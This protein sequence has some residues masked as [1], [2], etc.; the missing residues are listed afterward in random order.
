VCPPRR[1]EGFGPGRSWLC[2]G[3]GLLHFAFGD[4]PFDRDALDK[5]AKV[6]TVPD[7]L[8]V[9]T[10]N[11]TNANFAALN[12]TGLPVFSGLATGTITQNIGLNAS[13]QL[14]IGSA[15]TTGVN[16]T[17]FF[18]S[19][20]SPNAATPNAGATAGSL[21][22]IGNLIY[23]SVSPV[24]PGGAL[25]TA[26]N[27]QTLTCVTAGTYLVNFEGQVTYDSGSSG[28]PAILLLVNGITV[29][30]GP[31]RPSGVTTTL[32]AANISGTYSRRFVAG[33][34]ITLQLGSGSGTNTNV[35]EARVNLTRTGN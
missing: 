22:V 32:R 28:N 21:L 1:S 3:F 15:A 23:D 33:D 27:S 25:W 30:N 31:S 34:T 4:W 5:L 29:S 9:T 6:A 26:T 16:T 7:P 10:I 17:M 14:I 20:S 8:T 13:N 35:Y 12:V 24:V 2:K 11:A 19:P 18:E